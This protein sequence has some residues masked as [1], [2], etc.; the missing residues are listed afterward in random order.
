MALFAGGFKFPSGNGG[1][2]LLMVRVW[3][4]AVQPHLRTRFRQRGGRSC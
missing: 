1:A 3:Q 4:T 2:I